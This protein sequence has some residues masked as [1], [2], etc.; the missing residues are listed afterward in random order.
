MTSSPAID[1]RAQKQKTKNHL[2]F[3]PLKRTEALDP[4]CH[5]QALAKLGRRSARI[6]RIVAIVPSA[7]KNRY[8]KT[9]LLGDIHNKLPL[10]RVGESQ[11]CPW[12][13][14]LA[15]IHDS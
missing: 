7:Y 5:R 6:S 12:G 13:H 15:Y 3:V 1:N 4:S 9:A 10:H 2:D 11:S 14:V 8:S